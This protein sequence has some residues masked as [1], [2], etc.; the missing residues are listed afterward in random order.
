MAAIQR[1]FLVLAEE[2]ASRMAA[3][4]AQYR[5]RPRNLVVHYRVGEP[6]SSLS[7]SCSRLLKIA[8]RRPRNLVVNTTGRVRLLA[9]VLQYA[10][11]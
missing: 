5:R 6:Y 2:L 1:W 7:Q 10:C 9:V 11:M 8:R 3:D 4:E